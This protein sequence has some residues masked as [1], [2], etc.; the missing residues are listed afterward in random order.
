MPQRIGLLLANW[1]LEDRAAWERATTPT[2][3]FDEHAPADW[4]EKSL[5]QAR[6]A[7]GCWLAFLSQYSPKSLAHP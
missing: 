7:Y 5:R 2:T 3:F 6:Y 4:R 1:P